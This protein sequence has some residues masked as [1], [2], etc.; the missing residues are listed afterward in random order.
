[1][2]TTEPV[3]DGVGG[4]LMFSNARPN[5]GWVLSTRWLPLLCLSTLGMSAGCA[6]LGLNEPWMPRSALKVDGGNTVC[7]QDAGRRIDEYLN[8]NSSASDIT[9]MFECA[10][11]SVQIFLDRTKTRTPGTYTPN[12]LK[13]FLEKFFFGEGRISES[14]MTETMEFKR[15]LMGGRGDQLTASE[16]R[17]FQRILGGLQTLILQMEPYRP[18][19]IEAL[20]QLPREK[21]DE[22]LKS[23]NRG[24]EEFGAV[25][26]QSAGDY[27]TARL[28][29]LLKEFERIYPSEGLRTLIVRLPLV[30]ALKPVLLGT[31]ADVMRAEEWPR[32]LVSLGRLAGVYIKGRQ[33][34]PQAWSG[35]PAW[36]GCGAGRQSLTDAALEVFSIL[37]DAIRHHEGLEMIPLVEFYRVIDSLQPEDLGRVGSGTLKRLLGPVIRRFLAGLNEGFLGRDA[38]GLTRLGVQRARRA[39]TDW[40]NHQRYLEGAFRLLGQF[41]CRTLIDSP[42]SAPRYSW[43]EINSI[44]VERA[45]GV[46]RLED[47]A[48]QTQASLATFRRALSQ[49]MPLQVSQGLRV[50]VNALRPALRHTFNSASMINLLSVGYVLGQQGYRNRDYDPRRRQGGDLHAMAGPELD[51]ISDDLREISIDL[52]FQDPE[53]EMG[54]AARFRDGNLFTY[55][56]DGNEL[57]SLSEGVELLSILLSGKDSSSEIHRRIEKDCPSFPGGVFESKIIE[58]AC[59]GNRL[60]RQYSSYFGHLPGFVKYLDSLRPEGR[61][62]VFDQLLRIAKRSRPKSRFYNH[63]EMLDTDVVAVLPHYIESIFLVFDADRDGFLNTQEALSAY[64]RFEPTLRRVT[65]DPTLSPK[66]LQALFAFMLD[67]GKPP[68]SSGEKAS[69]LLWLWDG[70]KK[71]NLKVDRKRILDL[72]DRLQ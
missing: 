37:E 47:L 52:Q 59:F 62:A 21:L 48:P 64:P 44:P 32:L 28:E 35:D 49:I 58:I 65:N 10:E 30:R 11:D 22:V 66:D 68:E 14:L 71:W 5:V 16:L 27:P 43:A 61:S 67:R 63:M 6:K 38:E 69:F 17:T 41:D 33:L 3:I 15:S 54:G 53:G 45:M 19:N 1:L 9:H 36:A 51:V 39:L 24:L 25:L 29:G 18:F 42:G 60:T 8:G 20:S 56:A 23:L 2:G 26:A 12:E 46:L 55:S 50:E 40:S 13:N 57:L 4:W 72:F 7:L 70:P 31:P 34:A